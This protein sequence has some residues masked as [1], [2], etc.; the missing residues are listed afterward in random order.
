MQYLDRRLLLRFLIRFSLVYFAVLGLGNVVP[1][2][3]YGES[4]VRGIAS[5][6]LGLDPVVH[7]APFHPHTM[8]MVLF[9]ALVVS[10][11]KLGWTERLVSLVGG[12]VFMLL[13]AVGMLFADLAE[14]DLIGANWLTDLGAAMHR[15]AGAALLPIVLWGFY[16][17]A[18][19]R[20][21]Q[22]A[23]EDSRPHASG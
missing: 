12:S 7:E 13:I 17:S 21:T 18:R 2:Y 5:L 23:T 22:A 6:W 10:T 8:P 1:I 3:Q 11:P 15:T 20:Q 4:L 14:M 16:L 9:L 19:F